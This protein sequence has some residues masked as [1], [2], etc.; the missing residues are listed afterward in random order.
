MI[1]AYPV[2]YALGFGVAAVVA[3]RSGRRQGIDPGRWAQVLA[4]TA[5]AGVVGSRVLHFDL[6]IGGFGD[7]TFLGGLVGGGLAFLAGS[8]LLGVDPRGADAL[9]VAVP[10]GHAVGRLGCFVAGCC[11]G[12]PTT[13]PW[14][15]HVHSDL[16]G[17]APAD[18]AVHPVQLYEAGVQ[19]ALA[20]LAW[21][22]ASRFRRPGSVF[23][24][25]A[26]AYA[27][28]RAFLEGY[29]FDAWS[30]PGVITTQWLVALLAGAAIGSL[31]WRERGGRAPAWT[32][33]GRGQAVVIALAAVP[34]LLFLARGEA[35]THVELLVV[36]AAAVVSLPWAL[37]RIRGM[38]A[39]VAVAGAM[40]ALAGLFAFQAVADTTLER[41][42]YTTVGMSG[43]TGSYVESCG[44][45]RRVNAAGVSIA[46]ATPAGEETWVVTRAHGFLGT[47]ADFDIAGGGASI[48]AETPW[49]GAG[50]G[51]LAGSLTFD[52]SRESV[53]PTAHVRVGRREGLFLDARL[54]EHEPAGVPIPG[55]TVGLGLGIGGGSTA[56]VGIGGTGFYGTGVFVR[57]GWEVEPFLAM[58]NAETYQ[59]G[60]A[61][62]KRLGEIRPVQVAPAPG[63][64]EGR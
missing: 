30:Q 22:F 57:D 42:A 61:V 12:R 34:P 18:L 29:R 17:H 33:S 6:L 43:T 38:A 16:A 51:L 4:I 25:V 32:G 46:R 21:R 64:P 5:V 62:R 53:F 9:A 28:A 27:A 55:V 45:A 15:V 48:A 40:P 3:W 23:L 44:G 13:L 14:G 8:R 26:G 20:G 24:A 7:R 56:G 11:F 52:G 63:E 54:A 60:L 19:L 31:M 37:A 1:H 49:F 58:G 41:R 39:G 47:D 36:G 35:F 59:L 2:L 10:L 50:I